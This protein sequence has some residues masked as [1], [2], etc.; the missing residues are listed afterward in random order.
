[1]IPPAACFLA[2]VYKSSKHVCHCCNGLPS[3][4]PPSLNRLTP[5]N[6]TPALLSLP[7]CSPFVIIIINTFFCSPSLHSFALFPPLHFLAS[8]TRSNHTFLVLL[9]AAPSWHLIHLFFTLFLYSCFLFKPKLIHHSHR[10]PGP[11]ASLL[12]C[13]QN[14]Q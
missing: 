10:P 5:N 8:S 7:A 3:L 1:M 11:V 6:S 14:S 13:P 12:P 2:A 4:V 9:H